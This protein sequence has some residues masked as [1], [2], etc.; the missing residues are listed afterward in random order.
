LHSP[1]VLSACATSIPY[2]FQG[3]PNYGGEI[4]DIVWLNPDGSETKDDDWNQA[5]SHCLGVY[6]A[7]GKLIETDGRGRRLKDINLLL[8]LNAYHEDIAFRLPKFEEHDHWD[9]L[10]DTQ[11]ATGTP[12]VSR[13]KTEQAYPLVGRSLALLKQA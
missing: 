5:S 13:Y 4:K 7:G 6:F 2:F 10:L 12:D 8:L 1:D 11:D 9:V 3:S